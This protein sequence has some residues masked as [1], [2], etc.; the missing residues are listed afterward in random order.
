MSLEGKLRSTDA[1][2]AEKT[3]ENSKIGER[4]SRLRIVQCPGNA[5][6]G[7]EI[8]V[9]PPVC[10]AGL[11]MHGIVYP[12]RN[13]SH[14]HGRISA[15]NNYPIGQPTHTRGSNDPFCKLNYTSTK[16]ATFEKVG[17]SWN[18]ETG[19][20]YHAFIVCM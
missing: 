4:A 13:E 10:K 5:P 9:C 6:S 1:E 3:G 12:K 16:S 19:Q 8:L 18:G 14:L 11:S 17:K 20:S 7:A 2:A 15:G